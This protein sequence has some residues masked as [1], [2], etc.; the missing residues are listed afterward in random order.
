[1]EGFS[2]L[3][4]SS[5]K[6]CGEVLTSCAAKGVDAYTSK[7]ERV[8]SNPKPV[9]YSP[10]DDVSRT[11]KVG[12]GSA[13]C[14]CC[15]RVCY[16]KKGTC[17]VRNDVQKEREYRV[18][19]GCRAGWA[20]SRGAAASVRLLFWIAFLDR[21]SDICILIRHVYTNKLDICFRCSWPHPDHNRG[22][23][24]RRLQKKENPRLQET[25]IAGFTQI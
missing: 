3:H 22:I 20:L 21:V 19:I 18:I 12:S 5:G 4:G 6:I 1:M 9:L 14:A 15:N 11:G 25:Y 8:I 17:E 23:Q 7:E 16:D 13:K 24:A 2:R 10:R